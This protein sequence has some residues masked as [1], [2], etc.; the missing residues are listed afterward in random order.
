[1]TILCHYAEC[2]YSECL[3]LFIVMLIVAMLGVFLLNAI[4][5]SVIMLSVK[6]P[7][8]LPIKE[9]KNNEQTCKLTKIKSVY[10]NNV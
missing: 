5:L 1:M 10:L 2:H 7:L 3:I 8:P 9:T 4:M 6:A